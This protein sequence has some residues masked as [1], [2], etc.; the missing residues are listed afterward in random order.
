MLLDKRLQT[1]Q[2]LFQNNEIGDLQQSR[3]V[4][5]EN[6]ER[7]MTML[8]VLFNPRKFFYAWRGLVYA[9]Q[10]GVHLKI[11]FSI[12]LM[13]VIFSIFMQLSVMEWIAIIFAI[14]MVLITETLNT[15][16]EINVDLVTLKQRPRAMLAKD[17]AAGAVL[18]SAINSIVVGVLIIAS[19]LWKIVI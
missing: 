10:K 7:I 2:G 9:F 19:H 3:D 14:F 15:A 6:E 17:V 8:P 11:Q 16:I 5:H 13:M 18:L 4:Q 1:M 12:A